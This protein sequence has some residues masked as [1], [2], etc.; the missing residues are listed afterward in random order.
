MGRFRIERL[1]GLIARTRPNGA[2][3]TRRGR[4]FRRNAALILSIWF[5]GSGC[6]S[7]APPQRP[8]ALQ[9]MYR[10]IFTTG[11][12]SD[13]QPKNDLKQISI[14]DGQIVVY[15]DWFLL[16]IREHDYLCKIFDGRGT[17]VYVDQMKFDVHIGNYW[18]ASS[19]TFKRFVDAPGAWRFEIFLDGERAIQRTL[20]VLPSPSDKL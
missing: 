14:N 1:R 11:L 10:L 19:Y 7:L 5:F 6:G 4:P 16:P 17:L 9:T 2:K 18:T 3:L 12:A 13:N 20:D 15:V 8:Q